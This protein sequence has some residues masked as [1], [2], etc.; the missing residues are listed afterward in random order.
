MSLQAP[1]ALA[2]AFN[3]LFEMQ[4]QWRCIKSIN[5]SKSTFN[6]LF[7]MPSPCAPGECGVQL[8]FNSLFEMLTP[9]ELAEEL[10][11]GVKLSI[12]YLRCRCGGCRGRVRKLPPAFNSLFE[13]LGYF[14][15]LILHKRT[16]DAFNSLFEMP[17][18]CEPCTEW[19]IPP[20]VFQ[21]SI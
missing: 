13:M 17:I 21:F 11:L 8:A 7:E 6:S 4:L 2:A 16:F 19:H 12:L 3:S 5:M 18:D 10:R 14:V 1:S 9:G 15:S 20:C